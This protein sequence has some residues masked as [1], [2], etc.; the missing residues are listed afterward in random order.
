MKRFDYLIIGSNG[1]LGSNIKKILK[2]KKKKF[3]CVARSKSNFNLDLNNY[4]RL[5]KIFEKNKF[6]IVINCAGIIDLNYCEKYPK[7]IL[8]LN[9]EF[10]KY[11]AKL[12]NIFNFKHVHISSDHV[13]L[14][15][16]KKYNSEKDNTKGINN[17]A[18]SKIKAEKAVK[19]SKKYLIIR[20]NFTDKKNGKNKSFVDWIYSSIKNQKKIPLFNDMF[21]STIDV[22]NCAIF[23]IRLA[24]M[25]SYGIYNIGARNQTS[26]KEFALKFAKNIKKNLNF[27]DVSVNTSKIKRGKYLGLNVKKIQAK[28]NVKMPSINKV[29]DIISE[30]YL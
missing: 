19:K 2:I 26:K 15:K 21:V 8:K 9:Y 1:F 7:K 10:P 4:S 30:K 18:K 16:I 11:L 24:E 14:S 17:Y 28:L 23:I 3:F 12:S 6:N 25:T 13:Y 5:A 22:K 29:I 27:V 20:T